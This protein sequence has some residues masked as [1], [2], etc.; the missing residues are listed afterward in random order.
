MSLVSFAIEELTVV[1]LDSSHEMVEAAEM[2]LGVVLSEIDDKEDG[3]EE[4]GTDHGTATLWGAW[5]GAAEEGNV[6]STLRTESASE[7]RQWSVDFW[8]WAEP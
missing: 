4:D 3:T 7:T 6:I 1:G 2:S 8:Q 5:M